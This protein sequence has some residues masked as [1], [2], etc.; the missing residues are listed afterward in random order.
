M[1]RNA[2]AVFDPLEIPIEGTNLIEASAGTGKTYGIAALF[3]RM[4]LLERKSVDSILVVTFTKVATAEL[5]TRLRARLD[6]ALRWLS[7]TETERPDIDDFLQGLLDKALVQESSARLILRLKA[8]LSQFDNAAIYTIHGFCQR[9]LRDYAFLCQVPFDME[10]VDDDESRLLIPAQDFWREH[11]AHDA[12]AAQLAFKFNQ[13]PQSVLQNMKPYL[14][15]PVLTYRQPEADLAQAVEKQDEIWAKVCERLP[16]LERLFWQIQ[17]ALNGKSYKSSTFQNVFA[18]LQAG[19]QNQCLSE[20]EACYQKNLEKFSPEYLQSKLNKGKTLPDNYVELNLLAELIGA[21]Q[22]KKAAETGAANALQLD[23]L[24]YLKAAVAERKKTQRER[25]YD[26]L[27]LDV[28]EALTESPHRKALAAIVARS[29]PVALIDEFQDTDPLQYEIFRRTFIMNGN[30]LFLVGDPKQ[31][32]YSFRGADIYAYLQAAADADHHYTLARNYRSHASLVNSIGW[33]FRQKQRPFVLNDIHYADVTANRA[34]ACL[35][36]LSGALRV[37]WLNN[38]DEADVTKEALRSRAADYCA[39]EI[40]DALNCAEKGLFEYQGRPVESGDMAVLV[41][42]RNEGNM[43]GEAL[44]ARGIQSVLLQNESVFAGKEAPAMVAL[45]AFWLRPRETEWLRFALG[46][47]LFGKTADELHELNQ[48]E[49]MLLDYIQAAEAALE[50]WQQK[51][52]YAAMQ[53]FAARYGLES[54]LLAARNE[55]SL[56]NYHQILEFLAIEEDEQSRSPESLYQW[57]LSQIDAAK[58]G[59]KT[60]ENKS[61]RLESDEALV[62][63][64]TMHASKGL[65]YPIVFCPFIWDASQTSRVIGD[66]TVLH[67][68]GIS[69]LVSKEQL[70]EAEEN[71]VFDEELGERMRLLYVAMTRAKEQLTVYAAYFSESG[72]NTFAYLLEGGSDARREAVE[73][74]YKEKKGNKIDREGGMARLREGWQRA[75][76]NAPSDTDIVLMEGAP[77]AANHRG[78][79]APPQ[80]YGAWVP[81][82]R[83]FEHI[84]QTSFTGLLRELADTHAEAAEVLQPA[85]DPAETGLASSLSEN[86]DIAAACD[87]HHFPRGTHAGVCLHEL[88]EHFDFNRPADEQGNLVADTLARYGFDE[89]WRPA[90]SR[91]LD[92]TAQTVLFDGISLATLPAAQRLPEMDFILHTADFSPERLKAWFAGQRDAL[93]AE[94]FAA[95]Q[96]LDFD[97]VKGFLNGFIDM[98]CVDGGK[99]ACLIDYKSNYLGADNGAYTPESMNA[100]MAS[101]H[102]YLQAMIYAVAAARYFAARGVEM[103]T[104]HIRYLFLRGLDGGGHGVWHWSLDKAALQAWL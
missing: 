81:P 85:I 95:A 3:T 70:S 83:S 26:D 37:R 66:W 89:Q 30:P 47:V 90:A 94:C 32:I 64:V 46:S 100:A 101:H 15:R 5:K 29:W 104:I 57:L 56:T 103:E 97:T 13:T 63:I 18:A 45:L 9:L 44:K 69:E 12:A 102:Y 7:Q 87:I 22:A 55:R 58:G 79:Q 92:C 20:T 88:L 19:V 10:L 14:G 68:D 1:Q 65:E 23:F 4:V 76:D 54:G 72:R 24:N 78:W 99:T 67:H 93:P 17:P 40:A 62:K 42:T 21:V 82:A 96:Q 2:A 50:T 8:A 31:A 43:V 27:L 49:P 39:D 71:Q 34:D 11:V 60:G 51:G 35:K 84:R 6:E 74:A 98:T 28:Y 73:A 36:P 86:T 80:P 91:M 77:E 48:S 41:R 75:I 53:Q 61:L 25:G 38:P 16:E 59:E 33:L 52:I